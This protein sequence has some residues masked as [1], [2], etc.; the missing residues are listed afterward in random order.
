MSVP[1][2]PGSFTSQADYDR[3]IED[4]MKYLKL[5]AKLNTISEEST[6]RIQSGVTPVAPTPTNLDDEELGKQQIRNSIV[7][8]L[9]P[10]VGQPVAYDFILKYLDDADDMDEFNGALADFTPELQGHM[11]ITSD[12]LWQMWQRWKRGAMAEGSG[13]RASIYPLQQEADYLGYEI[14][15]NVHGGALAVA[16]LKAT[17]DDAVRRFDIPTLKA[18]RRQVYGQ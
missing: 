10:F 6:L 2:L 7:S 9:T 16:R 1:L 13:A 11:I 8:A 17:V 14:M 3:K 15:S 4:Q 5:R 12:Q 18:L